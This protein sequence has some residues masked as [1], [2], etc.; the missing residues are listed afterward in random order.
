MPQRCQVAGRLHRPSRSA[1]AAPPPSTTPPTAAASGRRPS[2]PAGAPTRR[3]AGSASAA[4][5]A[6]GGSSRRSGTRRRPTGGTCS[7]S[8]G[9]GSATWSGG[10]VGGRAAPRAGPEQPGGAAEGR[11]RVSPGGCQAVW[12]VLGRWPEEDRLER[13]SRARCPSHRLAL[14]WVRADPRRLAAYAEQERRLAA[15]EDE[16]PA[17]GR[18]PGLRLAG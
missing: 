1:A 9:C 11:G 18:R 4:T 8:S 16:G 14:A 15:A 13:C 17:G 6:A 2:R 5:S 3:R 7:A 12:V 10:A